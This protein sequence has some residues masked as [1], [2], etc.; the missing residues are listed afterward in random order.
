MSPSIIRIQLQCSDTSETNRGDFKSFVSNR[1][2]LIR[3]FISPHQWTY[4]DTL[5]N[6]ADDASRGMEETPPLQHSRWIKGPEFLWKPVLEWPQ[7]PFLLG[8]IPE[9]DPEI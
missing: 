1:V 4:V 7:Q 6:P 9:A 8:Q 5:N 3:D 2:Q